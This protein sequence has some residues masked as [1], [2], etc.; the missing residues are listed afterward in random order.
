MH[1]PNC[2]FKARARANYGSWSQDDL[3][4]LMLRVW[5]HIE[6]LPQSHHNMSWEDVEQFPLEVWSDS[7]A[8][9][10]ALPPAPLPADDDGGHR[11][12]EPIRSRSRSPFV[13]DTLP[14]TPPRRGPRSVGE[15]RAMI[16]S[17]IRVMDRLGEQLDRSSGAVRATREALRGLLDEP[18][19][20]RLRR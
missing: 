15:A 6:A 20:A 7:W 9:Q 17:C 14:E 13:V 3:D 12:R 18:R 2:R 8:T 19:E 1:C 5:Q 11:R 16:T 10:F 4:Q